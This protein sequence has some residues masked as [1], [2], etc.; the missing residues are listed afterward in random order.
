MALRMAKVRMSVLVVGTLFP[1]LAGAQSIETGRRQYQARC[2][3]CH[4]ADGTGG[5]HGPA[6]VNLPRPRAA[7]LESVRNLILKGIPDKGMPAFPITS[8]EATSIASHVMTLTA[9]GPSAGGVQAA[10]GDPLAGEQF[11]HG[12]GKCDTCHMIR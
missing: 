9:P 3:G 2:V 11:F 5:G 7:T 6:I 10:P 8:E 12:K 4:G 1:A